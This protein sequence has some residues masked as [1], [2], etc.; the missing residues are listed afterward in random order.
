MCA[1]ESTGSLS[2]CG[3]GSIHWAEESEQPLGAA[4]P[5]GDDGEGRFPFHPA[6]PRRGVDRG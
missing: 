1:P 5:P 4:P 6:A 2:L 3:A